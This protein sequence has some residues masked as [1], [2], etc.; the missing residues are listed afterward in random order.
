MEKSIWKKKRDGPFG[1]WYLENQLTGAVKPLA[2]YESSGISPAD[3]QLATATHGAQQESLPSCK[4]DTSE[5]HWYEN[6]SD[7]HLCMYYYNP[8]TEE[9]TWT[10]PANAIVHRMDSPS[11]VLS[12]GSAW[13]S[14]KQDE[15]EE[16]MPG[17]KEE[18]FRKLKFGGLS[19]PGSTIDDR[20]S[21]SAKCTDPSQNKETA[22]KTTAR[23]TFRTFGRNIALNTG[24]RI[25]FDTKVRRPGFGGTQRSRFGARF[26]ALGPF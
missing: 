6:W 4:V 5:E 26:G 7:E 23:S 18:G 21:T 13:Q 19:M 8:A 16:P 9:S 11:K 3:K 24:R 15:K 10:V 12:T 2:G 20:T 22:S 25:G 14:T 1:V 17:D